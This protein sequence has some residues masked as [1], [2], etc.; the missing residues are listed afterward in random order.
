M[1]ILFGL[2]IAVA[3]PPTA[4]LDGWYRNFGT[5]VAQNQKPKKFKELG[6]RNS[7]NILHTIR[8]TYT[9]FTLRGKKCI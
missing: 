4:A 6:Y 2:N 9:T 7:L 1:Y 5:T 8:I 3:L